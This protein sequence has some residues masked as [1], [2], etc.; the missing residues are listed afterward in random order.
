MSQEFAQR[1]IQIDKWITAV[2]SAGARV[3]EN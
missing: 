3:V 2:Q 1:S